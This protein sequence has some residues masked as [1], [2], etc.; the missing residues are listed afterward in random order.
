MHYNA[1]RQIV[2]SMTCLLLSLSWLIME[3]YL[4]Q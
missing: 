1:T 4:F 3:G 2:H